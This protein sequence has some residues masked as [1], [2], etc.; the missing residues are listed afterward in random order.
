MGFH[1]LTILLALAA[2]LA[3][4]ALI[5]DAVIP[6]ATLVSVE[7]RSRPRPERHHLGEALLGLGIICVGIMLFADEAWGYQNLVMLLAVVFVAVGVG[8][9]IKYVRGLAFGPA[10]GRVLRRRASDPAPPPPPPPTKSS[11]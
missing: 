7:R 2:A 1:T 9:N 8:L 10:A 11:G 6:E 4:L 5:A 3:G